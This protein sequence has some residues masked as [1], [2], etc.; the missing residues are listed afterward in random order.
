MSWLPAVCE[1]V[2]FY[3]YVFPYLLNALRKDSRDINFI[4]LSFSPIKVHFS[5]KTVCRAPHTVILE[6]FVLFTVILI[7]CNLPHPIQKQNNCLTF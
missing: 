6:I 2:R 4:Y 5:G 3:E 7:S 1:I